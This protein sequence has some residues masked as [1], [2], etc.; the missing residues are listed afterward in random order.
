MRTLRI[1]VSGLVQEVGYR[2]FT[3]RLADRLGVKGWVKNLFDGRVEVLA[4]FPDEE[5]ER[6]F[7]SE[8]EQ[9]PPYSN[10]TSVDYTPEESPQEFSHFE[11]TF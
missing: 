9:G 11:I 3:K 10:V 5:T 8:L 1:K 4:Q 7:L 6:Q 2:Y